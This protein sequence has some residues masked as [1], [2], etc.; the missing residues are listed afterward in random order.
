MF[1]I[2]RSVG[3]I[4][5]N[6]YNFRIPAGEGVGIL[7]VGWPCRIG[8]AVHRYAAFFNP[9]FV[10]KLAVIIDEAYSIII[11]CV[12]S[13]LYI[14]IQADLALRIRPVN[15]I[16]PLNIINR[17]ILPVSDTGIMT[18][19]LYGIISSIAGLYYCIPLRIR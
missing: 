1:C 14:E 2:L 17:H 9:G 12:F 8:S 3:R 4:S 13:C 6:R 10:K 19:I 16:V 11:A 5:S 15:I 7:R 18:I